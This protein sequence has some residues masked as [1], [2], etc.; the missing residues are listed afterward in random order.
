ML[1]GVATIVLFGI[2]SG[3]GSW[4][5]VLGLV[6]IGELIAVLIGLAVAGTTGRHSP[7]V[8]IDAIIAV[9]LVALVVTGF[10]GDSGPAVAVSFVAVLLIVV[11][12]AAAILGARVVRVHPI[13]RIVL[14]FAL[15]PVVAFA[16]A[17][18]IA[19]LVPLAIFVALFAPELPAPR[20][21]TGSGPGEERRAS[22]P[23]APRRG[24]PDAAA[25]LGRR[26]SA[27]PQPSD[28]LPDDR[29]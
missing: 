19:T 17:F 28:G 23:I 13:E 7:L 25:I 4:V 15:G 24:A 10:A 27:E 16:I 14:G 1:L 9:P 5:A 29:P 2:P 3:D 18:P 26:P 11:A 21:L 20:L 22:V 12:V 8:T 6:T